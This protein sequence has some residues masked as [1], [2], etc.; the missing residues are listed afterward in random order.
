MRSIL[1]PRHYHVYGSILL[2]LLGFFIACP[3][4][5]SMSTSINV[6]ET[7][8][9]L[10]L[11]SALHS[12]RSRMPLTF[13]Q[14][15]ALNNNVCEAFRADA[16]FAIDSALVV[17][18]SL[19]NS[20]SRFRDALLDE[21]LTMDIDLSPIGYTYV[22]PGQ[23]IEDLLA[24]LQAGTLDSDLTSADIFILNLGV[25][26]WSQGEDNLPQVQSWIDQ[27]I[28]YV[29]NIAPD[30][31]IVWVEPHAVE[32]LVSNQRVYTG[33][34]QVAAYLNQKDADGAICLLDWSTYADAN[35]EVYST[36]LADI[37]GVHMFGNEGE[38]V[39]FIVDNIDLFL[40]QQEITLIEGDANCDGNLTATDSLLIL[41]Y[42]VGLRNDI[43]RCPLNDPT[44][45]INAAISDVNQDGT[46][47][48]ADALL[49][50]QC[51]VEISNDFC[52]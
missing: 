3:A 2:A 31:I 37:D 23:G 4:V 15:A 20:E 16:P 32:D 29:S 28:A 24:I 18:D 42:D 12:L 26:N 25:N 14:N 13:R 50:L 5:F 52:P 40:L 6:E 10:G 27:V 49:I 35:P 46:V 51:E 38:Y 34:L 1:Y 36:A 33:T 8:T 45:E 41:Q 21:L 7:T 43:G 19:F 44:T 47:S 11:D 9:R 17:G 22:V 48:S 39:G 30:L